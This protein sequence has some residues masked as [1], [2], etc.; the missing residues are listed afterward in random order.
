MTFKTFLLC[1]SDAVVNP[2]REEW[3]F[4]QSCKSLVRKSHEKE[5]HLLLWDHCGYVRCQCLVPV[6]RYLMLRMLTFLAIEFTFLWVKAGSNKP[7]GKSCW[8]KGIHKEA[9]RGL[10]PISLNGRNKFCQFF[11]SVRGGAY[12]SNKILRMLILLKNF[13]GSIYIVE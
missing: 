5:V 7:Q 9:A 2:L 6:H 8:E 12:H 1:V 3:Y 13:I 10:R 11:F 4:Q